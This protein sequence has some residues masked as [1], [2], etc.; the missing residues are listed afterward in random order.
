MAGNYY[1]GGCS[2]GQ[3]LH[4]IGPEEL[5][6]LARS[7]CKPSPARAAAHASAGRPVVALFL[8]T[9]LLVHIDKKTE[10]KMARWDIPDVIWSYKERAQNGLVEG[11]TGGHM[12]TEGKS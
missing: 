12:V 7:V 6:S 10:Q 5:I 11:H 3:S 8:R 2:N 4:V 9:R 1:T